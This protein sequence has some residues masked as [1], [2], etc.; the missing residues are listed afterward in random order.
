M[1]RTILS[2]RLMIPKPRRNYILRQHLF[3]R[4]DGL[5]YKK[6]T[7]IK[8]APG[9]GKTTLI[10]S[11]LDQNSLAVRWLDQNGLAVRWLTLDSECNDV[12]L[13]WTYAAEALSGLLDAGPG[14]FTSYLY[15]DAGAHTEETLNVLINALDPQPDIYLVLDDF[16][17]LQ[18]LKLLQ[19][20]EYFITNA[21]A[22]LHFIL[23]TREH[24]KLYLTGCE[25]Q[26]ELLR[27]EEDDLRLEGNEGLLFLKQTLKLPYP[28]EVLME[29]VCKAGG[30]IGGL[31]LLAAALPDK[32]AQEVISSGVISSGTIRSLV[33]D[34]ITNEM[35]DRLGHEEQDFLVMT[36]V[37]TYFNCLAAKALVP[38]VNYS[39]MLSGLLDKNLM[40][41]CIDEEQ[42]FY[43]Y[44]NLLRDYLL[45]QFDR[46]TTQTKNQVY[47]KAAGVFHELGDEEESLRHLFLLKDYDDAMLR[48]LDIPHH[49][50][51]FSSMKKVPVQYAVTNF[52]FAFQTFFYHYYIYDYE[53]CLALYYAAIE[54]A[55]ADRRYEA[56]IGTTLLFNQE[57]FVFGEELITT[58]QVRESDSYPLTKALILTKN[59]AFQF[60]QD[61]FTAA[62]QSVNESMDYE[63]GC[64]GTYIHYFNLTLKAQICEEMGLL[65]KAVAVQEQTYRLID[66]N[67]LL[68]RLHTPTFYVTIAGLYMKQMRLSDAEKTLNACKAE[69]T[70]RGGQLRHSYDYN[71][72][73]YLYLTGSHDEAG[74]LLYRLM[75]TKP[76]EDILIVSSLLKLMY[77]AG[78]MTPALQDHFMAAY[79]KKPKETRS[80]NSRLL[81]ARMLYSREKQQEAASILDEVMS[82]ARKQ[83]SCLKIVEADLQKLSML[84]TCSK[85]SRRMVDLY[86]EALY[87][88][89]ENNI[90]SPFFVEADTVASLHQRRIPD[91]LTN[92]EKSFHEELMKLCITTEHCILSKREVEILKA[93]ADGL[94]NHEIAAKLFISLPTVKTHISNIYRKLEVKTRVTALDQ[95]RA[96]GII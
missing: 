79:E 80:L 82:I 38:D 92:Q 88:A 40:L 67:K 73:E 85:D 37:P 65:N 64:P 35:W 72:I 61:Q 45:A 58:G 68:R 69:I 83:N 46:L 7:V 28:D 12:P 34:Y 89:S 13:F 27:I 26:G 16:H 21:P 6:L 76:Y 42:G 87:Y 57:A 62:L 50:A 25:M 75:E 48:I 8:G 32:P 49:T 93:V 77:R 31:Q 70:E 91:A 86:K 39:V 78:A 66:Q 41:Q 47:Q 1:D 84:V 94:T 14:D 10:T 9:S 23:L 29:L 43:R 17:V 60:H 24:P 4:L 96:M 52:D 53:T 2:T 74:K 33:Y 44:H 20:I 15:C 95:A 5:R 22:N 56:F 54:Y 63:K 36:A 30:W 18:S 55:A 3:R 81:Y 19:S 51:H 59:A 90:R 11:W 71:R